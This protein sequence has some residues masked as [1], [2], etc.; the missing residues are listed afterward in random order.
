M[1]TSLSIVFLVV[2]TM[3]WPAR[4]QAFFE[5]LPGCNPLNAVDTRSANGAHAMALAANGD[6]I[7]T[8]CLRTGLHDKMLTMRFRAADGS[9]VWSAT[10]PGLDQGNDAAVAVAMDA[11]GNVFVTGSVAVVPF[12]RNM[13]TVKY[14]GATGAQLWVATYEARYVSAAYAIALDAAGDV[15]VTG[16]GWDLVDNR[17]VD[18]LVT[19]K[20]S[21]ATGA[22]TWTALP[23][24]PFDDY[25]I[26]HAIVVDANGDAFV[27]GSQGQRLGDSGFVTIKYA[28]ASGAAL[29]RSALG[30]ADQGLDGTIAPD[31]SFIALGYSGSTGYR[32]VKYGS[33]T[34]EV[35]W[36]RF[37]DFLPRG[38]AMNSVAVDAAG[39]VS[40]TGFAGAGGYDMHTVNLLAASG[41]V[42]WN[43]AYNGA[44]NGDD[45]SYS[46]AVDSAGDVVTTGVSRD[47]STAG[48]DNLRTIKYRGSDGA[49][50]WTASYPGQ[51]GYAVAFDRNRDVIVAARAYSLSGYGYTVVK[52]SGDTGARRWHTASANSVI[53]ASSPGPLSGIWWN[54]SESGWGIDFT[55]RNN[56][57]FVAWYSYDAAGKPKW[58]VAPHC[59]LPAGASSSGACSETVYEVTGPKFFGFAFDPA[60]AQVTPIGSLQLSFQNGNAGT[61]TYSVAGQSRAVTIARQPFPSGDIAPPVN[62]TDLWWDPTQSGW[63]VAITHQFKTMFLAWYVYDSAGKPVWYVASN[64]DASVGDA[65]CSGKVYRTTGPAFGPDFDPAQVRVVEVGTASVA[66]TDPNNGTLNFSVDGVT[67]SKTITR[68]VF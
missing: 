28:G 65:G 49:P 4:A 3:M 5:S 44:G 42:R 54:P 53:P 35:V 17:S 48:D 46:L 20:Y 6:A 11:A 50:L 39:N 40:V 16:T 18:Y 37:L 64:C 12:R 10:H 52:Y 67:G 25:D 41:N 63:G 7:V 43:V 27:T 19:V 1:R 24:F 21:G 34:G 36:D 32:I 62:F 55:Q 14:D 61:M 47:S 23:S 38:G 9:V 51:P 59:A 2:V 56:I 29:W 60:A 45:F 31:G 8:G 68:Q 58:Y 33:A 13:R 26:G 30:L 22:Q 66:F 57:V 15:F